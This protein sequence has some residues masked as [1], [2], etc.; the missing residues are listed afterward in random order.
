[1]SPYRTNQIRRHNKPRNWFK[2]I[3]IIGKRKY[4][5]YSNKL[6]NVIYNFIRHCKIIVLIFLDSRYVGEK[7]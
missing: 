3:S 4:R 2:V 1:M 6:N 5:V 7:Y